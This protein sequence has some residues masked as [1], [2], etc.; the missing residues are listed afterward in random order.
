MASVV[1]IRA[2]LRAESTVAGQRE[3]NLLAWLDRIESE[4]TY[5]RS[6]EDQDRWSD[7]HRLYRGPRFT[8]IRT[9]PKFYL[10][11][12]RPTID[13]ANALLLEQKPSC[14]ILPW[15]DGLQASAEALEKLFEAHWL[16]TN[17]QIA[18][19]EM[20]QM[21][22]IFG[23]AGMDL[24]W[25][26]S[27]HHGQGDIDPTPLDPR[28]VIFDPLVRKSRLLER[29]MYIRIET[30]KNIWDLQ[31]Q[32]PGRGMLVKPDA[33]ISSVPNTIQGSGNQNVIQ[34]LQ[35]SFQARMRRLEEGPIPRKR[36]REYWVRDPN[37]KPNGEPIMPLGRKIERAGELILD[38]SENPYWDGNW[39]AEWYD[40]RP[41]IDTPWG[42]SEVEALRYLA[43]AIN[44][45]GHL[46]VENTI[47][48]GNLVVI[49][50]SDAI[51]NETRNK[52]TNA[53]A[54]FI[55]KKFG[56]NLEWR[57]P[58]PM[59]P[60]M[61][62][63]IPQALGFIDYETGMRDGMMEGRGRQEVRSGVQLEGLQN[64]A[65][66]LIKA[67]ARRLEAFLERLGMKWISRIFQFYPTSRLMYY[68]DPSTQEYQK[69]QF[70]YG[71]FQDEFVKILKADGRDATKADSI[72]EMMKTAWSEFA[73]KINPLS[74]L[75][76]TKM[77]RAQLL[78]QL[79]EM[80]AL[81]RSMILREVGYYNAGDLLKEAQAEIQQFGP[82]P[83]PKK[84]KGK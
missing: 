38:D 29:A 11:T 73:F 76:A 49:G 71:T 18:L 5:W 39:P 57:A 27:L 13:R 2:E 62:G 8:D 33:S 66:I 4:G 81:P 47:L 40:N 72:K 34:Q 84:N 1:D 44:R 43:D 83:S 78:M 42:R 50:D 35:S 31:A 19:E 63:F 75:A 24:T 12:I 82:P 61:M 3:K 45:I 65:Q 20:R 30:V 53:S 6:T 68:M 79:V 15:R 74:T 70:Q 52:L 41:D 69:F 25:N 55:A 46:F 80:G 51:S 17:M 28:Q 60:H 10:N 23:S 36:V 16:G 9:N 26:N 54:L 56:R 14:K 58:Q 7:W 22:S 77:A 59:P 21:A 32:Y 48:G 64:A 67:S 37:R